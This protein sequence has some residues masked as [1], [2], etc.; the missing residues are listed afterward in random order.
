MNLNKIKDLH[1]ENY[2][3]LMKKFED[4]WRINI[5]KTFILPKAIYGVNVI[6]TM[7]PFLKRN[8]KIKFVWNHKDP[9]IDKA[10]L[11]KKNKAGG[12]KFPYFKQY[13]K[14]I[15]IKTVSFEH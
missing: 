2:K 8:K 11:R 6:P 12:K 3:S 15:V 13:Y 1:T 14:A 9:Q 7:I 10:I 4:K 5:V